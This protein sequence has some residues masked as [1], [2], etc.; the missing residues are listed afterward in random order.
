VV[1]LGFQGKHDEDGGGEAEGGR[2]VARTVPPLVFLE[3]WRWADQSATGDRLRIGAPK[4]A[5]VI[6]ALQIK[7]LEGSGAAKPQ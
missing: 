3:F 7:P 1:S 2:K 6:M 4:A 5:G